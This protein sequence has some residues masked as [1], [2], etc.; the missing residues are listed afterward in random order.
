MPVNYNNAAANARLAA[1]FTAAV[2]GQAVDGGPGPGILVIG[3]SS[4][5]GAT[6]VLGSLT[7]Q[8]PCGSIASRVW[9]LAGVPFTMTPTANGTAALG[10]LRDS[11]GLT[12]VSGLTVGTAG[13]D[14]IVSTVTVSTSIPIQVT[15]GTISHP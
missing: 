10:E 13:T 3:T 8:K 5:S 15:A 2:A 1:A 9:T 14:I 12:I 11:T 4:L 7:L 6:G